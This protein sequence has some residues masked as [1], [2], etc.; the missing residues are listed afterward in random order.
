MRCRKPTGLLLTAVSVLVLGD[1]LSARAEAEPQ[2]VRIQIQSRAFLPEEIT[3][4]ANRPATLV[5]DN[6]DVEI[7]V[8][9]PERLLDHSAVH[10]EGSGAP[11]FGDK[12]LTRLLVPGGGRAEIRF[13][14]RIPGSYDYRCDMPGHRMAGQIIVLAEEAVA[15]GRIGTHEGTQAR[16]SAP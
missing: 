3:L 12:G 7:H 4:H 5:F 8:F 11:I 14:P 16:R 9:A 10:I 15:S 1:V 13:V 2:T 6:Q